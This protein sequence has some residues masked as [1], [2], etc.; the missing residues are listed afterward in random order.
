M[1]RMLENPP[2]WKQFAVRWY[3]MDSKDQWRA[4]T[5]SS[6]RKGK[7]QRFTR[8]REPFGKLYC[9]VQNLGEKLGA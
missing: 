6:P 3:A 9:T 4:C 5:V 8:W 7:A 1:D 2:S